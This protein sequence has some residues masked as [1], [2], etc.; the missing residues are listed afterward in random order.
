MISSNVGGTRKARFDWVV[1]DVSRDGSWI[2]AIAQHAFEIS[3]L[4][5]PLT[6]ASPMDSARALLSHL[7]EALQI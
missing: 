6:V 3:F 1:D 5:E 7:R 4:P 2:V